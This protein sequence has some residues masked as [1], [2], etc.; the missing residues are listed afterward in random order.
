MI[1]VDDWAA[2]RRSPSLL[3][4]V[5]GIALAVGLALAA[6]A[7]AQTAGA[8]R[9]AAGVAS[10]QG[11]VAAP[12]LLPVAPSAAAMSSASARAI[13][14]QARV[15]QSLNLA[16]QANAAARAAAAGGGSAVPNGLTPGG[17]VVAPAGLQGG[18]GQ[19][20]GAKA[21]VQT[22]AAGA[23]LVTV[24]QTQP[25][26]LLSWSSFNIGRETT[27]A[28]TQQPDWIV[29][30]RIVDNIDP[31]TGAL[32][33]SMLRPSQILGKITAAGTVLVINQNGILF[34]P[35]AQVNTHS[36]LVASLEIGSRRLVDG[37]GNTTPTTLAQRSTSFLQNG[38]LASTDLLSA[39][40]VPQGSATADNANVEGAVEIAAGAQI[41]SAKGGYVI[42]AAPRVANAGE[43]TSVEGQ[44]SLQSGRQVTAVASSGAANSAD[45]DVRGLVLT[46]RSDDVKA[47]DGVA[48]AATGT[49]SAP[50]G[51]VSLG[52]TATAQIRTD[53]VLTATT[54][55]ARNGKIVLT[56]AEVEVGAAA[57]IAITPDDNARTDPESGSTVY[58]TIPQ[59]P[60]SVAAFKRSVITIGGAEN[61]DGVSPA[62]IDIGANALIYAPSATVAIGGDDSARGEDVA[63]GDTVRASAL[64]VA[65]GATIDVGGI[66]DFAVPADRNSIKI[67]PVKRNELRDTPNY[68]ETTTDGS[69]TLNGATLYVDPRKSGVRA[70]GVAWVG[71]PLVEAESYYHQVGV[72]VGELMTS[73]GSLTLGVRSY[74]L[75]SKETPA[76]VV[77]DPGAVLDISGG[78][79]S[80][81]AGFVRTSRLLTTDGRIVDI[82]IA[83]P[84]DNFVA[85]ID[86]IV[87]LQERAN[88]SQSFAN[89]AQ[90]SGWEPAYTEGRDAGALTIKG[91]TNELGGTLF[92]QAFA[93]TQQIANGRQGSAVP[94]IE[95]DLRRLQLAPSE[96]PA[97][98]LL[99][100]AALSRLGTGSNAAAIAGGADIVVRGGTAAAASPADPTILLS[101]D[102]LA[103]GGFAQLS[104]QTSG[105]VTLAAD[106]RIA[107]EPGGALVVDAGRAIRLD[108]TVEIPSGRIVARTYEIA[109][110]S[111]FDGADDLPAFLAADPNDPGRADRAAANFGLFDLTV[112][113]TLS[114]RGR[115]VND[116]L[117]ADGAYLGGA[118]TDGGSISLAVAPR[119]ILPIATTRNPQF[120]A[121][122]S[123]RLTLAGSAVLDVRG[124]AHV[125]PDAALALTGAGG[126]VELVNETTYFQVAG[127]NINTAPNQY[128]IGTD[129]SG[130]QTS[131]RFG[132]INGAAPD[133]RDLRAAVDIA[134]GARIEG[135]GFAAGGHFTLVTPDLDFGATSDGGGTRLTSD[136]IREAGFANYAITT[137]KSRVTGNVFA[138][139]LA[140]MT[141]LLDTQVVR[142]G[143]GEALDL[144]RSILND[145]LDD[146]AVAAVRALPTGGDV[147]SLVGAA[148]PAD[149]WDRRP[150]SLTFG[151]L[152]EV[153]VAA[154]GAVTGADGASLTVP[155]LLNSG[156]IRLPGGT[157]AQ[158]EALPAAYLAPDRAALGV[159][160]LSALFGAP[161]VAGRFDENAANLLGI[162]AGSSANSPV[163]SNAD[164]ATDSEFS[165]PIYFTA[166][167]AAS[168][169]VR[170]GAGSVTDL[171][172]TS[173]RN[174]RAVP[175]PGASARITGRL[176]DGGS[177]ATA[178]ART[179]A[180]ELFAAPD[181]GTARYIEPAGSAPVGTRQAALGLTAEGADLGRPAALL[182]IGGAA[183]RWHDEIALGSYALAPVWSDAG[184]L[185]LAGGGS[186]AGARIDAHGGA[187]AAR[188][189]TL[190]WANPILV[191]SDAP[192]M[193]AGLVS[194]DSITAAGFDAFVAQGRLSAQGDVTL[195][196]GRSFRLTGPSWTGDPAELARLT[197]TLAS[198]GAL[199][200]RA[201]YIRLESLQQAVLPRSDAGLGA[202]LITFVGGAADIVGAVYVEQ[203]VAATRFDLSG[204]LRLTGVQPAALA[205]GTAALA[206]AS[207]LGGEFVVNG[208]LTIKAAQVYPTTG[209]GSLQAA[210]D[211]ERGGAASTAV[212]YRLLSTGA[213]ATIRF[214][215]AQATDPAAPYSAGGNLLVQAAH[216]EQAG[217]LRV[218]LGRLQ[219]GGNAPLTL[220]TSLINQDV[221]ATATLDILA[222]STTSVSLGG[223]AG[224]PYG[225]TTD[226]LEYFF[227]P[228]S[229]TRLDAPPAADLR[230]AGDA[231]VIGANAN[232]DTSGGGDIYAYEFVPGVGG[233]RDVLDR[234]N[235]DAFSSNNGLQYADGRQ[236]YAVLP[237][238]AGDPVAFYDPIYSAD[239]ALYG[240]DA[241]KRVFLEAAPGLEEGWY[242]L[243][244]ARY[245]L[246]PGALRVVENVG[247][248]APARGVTATLR[249]GSIVVGGH[250]GTAGTAIEQSMRR[251]FTV[252]N[253]ATVRKFS[254]I[255]LTSATETFTDLA[256]RSKAALP[257]LPADAARLVLTPLSELR[258]ASP[259]AGAPAPGGRG[260]Q[261]DI[262]GTAFEILSPGAAPGGAGISLTTADFANLSAASLLIGGVRTDHADGT[263]SLDITTSTIRIANDA[264]SPLTAPEIV[265]AVD[266]R[267]NPDPLLPPV[268]P[269]IDIADGAVIAATGVL[270]DTRAGDYIIT[271]DGLQTA[272]GGIV[273]VANGPERLVSRPGATALA[274]SL[275]PA[276]IAI[277]DATLTGTAILLD[278]SRDL[279]ITDSPASPGGPRITAT[280]LALGGDDVFF[281]DA[282][283]G[284]L[285]LTV[286]PALEAQ[287][288]A[289]Q[290]LTIVTKSIVG[291]S[292]GAHRFNDLV[293]DAR[294]IR[295]FGQAVEPVK[296][297]S[298]DV[299]QTDTLVADPTLPIGV[300]IAARD[301]TL[302]NSDRDRGACSGIGVDGCGAT[303]NTLTIDAAAIHFASGPVRTYG[304]DKAVTFNAATG[305][306]AEGEASFDVGGAAITLGTPYLGDR[307]LVADP[308]GT[309]AQPALALATSGDVVIAKSAGTTASAPAAAP[310]ARLTIGDSGAP[311]RS[312]RID[313]A[314]LR[315][316]AGVIDIRAANDI[317]VAGSASIA[318]P[319]YAKTFGDAADPVT[320]SAPGG[321]VT[322]VSL[323]G[324]VDFA[325]EASV[326]VG[327]GSGSAGMLQLSAA[328]GAVRLPGTID[329]AAPSGKASLRLD[330]G[331]NPLLAGGSRQFDLAAFLAGPGAA[332]TG[333]VR[334]RTG[335]GDLVLGAGQTLRAES[336]RL[337]A[338]GGLLAIAGRID[339]SGI[340]GGDIGLFGAQ[341]VA[342][343][344]TASLDAHAAGYVATD[345]RSAT[346]GDIVI[347]TAGAGRIDVAAGAVIDVAAR[348]P[349]ARL[350]TVTRKDALTLSDT[351]GYDYAAPDEG[352]TL[353]LRAPVA[354]ATVPIGFAGTVGGAREIAVEGVRVFDLGLLAGGATCAQAADICINVAGQAV[355]DLAATPGA[356]RLA[357]RLPGSV[358]EFVQD[359]AIDTT[360]LGTLANDPTL[361]LRPGVELA[362][363]GDIVLASNWNL[364][365]GTVDT[366]QA[367]AAKLM[368]ASPIDPKLLYVVPGAEASVLENFTTFLYRTGGS[369]AGTAGVLTL[370][371]GGDLDIRGSITDGF[372]AF[373]DQTEPT[374]LSYQLGGGDRSYRPALLTQCGS[375]GNTGGYCGNIY[376]AYYYYPGA[377][378]VPVANGEIITINAAQLSLGQDL[379]LLEGA[380]DVV[381]PYNPLANTPGARGAATDGSGDPIGTAEL[382]PLLADGSAV[383][384]FSY[385]LVGGAGL[386]SADPLAVSPAS[387]GSVSVSGEVTYRAVPVKPTGSWAGGV[388]LFGPPN[389][390]ILEPVFADPRDFAALSEMVTDFDPYTRLNFG[391]NA[392]LRAYLLQTSKA[393]FAA[394]AIAATDYQYFGPANSPNVL[395][396]GFA[397]MSDYLQ[398]IAADFGNRIAN[399]E[400]GYAQPNARA[401]TSLSNP[402]LTARSLVRTGTGD[403]AIT[404]AGDV[405]LTNGA[406]VFRNNAGRTVSAGAASGAQVGGT[407]VYTAGRRV[408]PGIMAA[409][410]ADGS[411]LTVDAAAN[412][413]TASVGD[414][415]QPNSQ[416]ILLADPVYAD[417][418][419]SVSV[420]AGRDVLG[421]RDAWS[422]AFRVVRGATHVGSPTQLWR[423]G[424]IGGGDAALIV[425]QR[426]NIR[427]N[428]QLFGSGFGTLGGGDIEV[429]AWRD[430]REILAAADTSVTS[431]AV[432][433]GLTLV[434]W[435]GGDVRITAGRDLLGGQVDVAEGTATVRAGRNM[436]SSGQLRL[437]STPTSNAAP[438]ANQ[439][440][441]RV[442]NAPADLA[443]LGS[444]DIAG[445]TALGTR[446]T[447]RAAAA[448]YTPAAG[449]ALAANGDITLYNRGREL[450]TDFSRTLGPVPVDQGALLPGS[451]AAAS[452]FGDVDLSGILVDGSDVPLALVPSPTG[453]LALFAGGDIGAMTL[454]MDDGDPSLAPGALSAYGE[455]VAGTRLYGFPTV[456]PAVSD[457]QRRIAHNART[458]HAGDTVPVRIMAEGDID[459]VALAL[460][461]AARISAGGDI[462]D[463]VFIGQNIAADDVTRITAGGDIKASARVLPVAAASGGTV[464]LP[465]LQG[466]TFTLGGPGALFI[467]A[468]RDLGPFLN[469]ATL[470]G[471]LDYAGGILTVG[472]DNNPWLGAA[473]A[474]IYTMFGVAGGADFTAFRDYYVNPANAGAL[475]G[476]LFVQVPDGKGNLLPDRSQPI[477]SAKLIDWTLD[478]AY[479]ALVATYGAAHVGPPGGPSAVTAA[480]AFAVFA[481]LPSL[482]QQQFLID[483][484][485]FN[486]LAA[487]ADVSGPSFQQFKRGYAA[488]DRLFPA[489]RGYTANDLS[490]ASN[491]GVQVTT[492]NFDLRLASLET[493]RGG[494]I[495][496]L[497]P[498][499]RLVAGSVVATAAQ[500]ARR[501][502]PTAAA[503]NLFEGRRQPLADRTA[504]ARILAIPAG[505]EGILTLRGGTVRGFTDDDLLLNQSRLF[506]IDGG[507]VFLWSSNGDLN[508]GQGART[509]ANNPPVVVRF[510]PNAFGILDQAGTVAGA[511]IAA[512]PPSDSTVPSTVYLIAPAGTVDAGDA[513]VRADRAVVL[514]QQVANADSIVA[515]D[516]V[517]AI[518]GV[519]NDLAAISSASAASTA[520]AQAAEAVDPTGS[521]TDTGATRISVEV[522]GFAGEPAN[523]PCNLTGAARPKNCPVPGG[524]N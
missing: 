445:I 180:G 419:G 266:R 316:S 351:P 398:S 79:V 347:G 474:K 177:L 5:S 206:L 288:A 357:D 6:P 416:G 111:V 319:G 281:T 441:L 58:D 30:N 285:G 172:G 170:L 521:R 367:V 312:V 85:V 507:D 182:A 456:T 278:S 423:P 376:S 483:Q 55:V 37:N 488:V 119:V 396:A 65:A 369:A 395:T 313:G 64:H 337:T 66:K 325:P 39:I 2:S 458:T 289:A 215:R 13:A 169:G 11:A 254:R 155:K 314:A 399:G 50:R 152:T 284:F 411:V 147:A 519:S 492:G 3:R 72:R 251:S 331:L 81:A 468:G 90:G 73:G 91:S 495:A 491:G 82:S 493:V 63:S 260:A 324:N 300:T 433:G 22:D 253:E 31:A 524:G 105:K 234:A 218:P 78:W 272:I 263:T 414:D 204:D 387:A 68:R 436:A 461:K 129:R 267:A 506:T 243:L 134:A 41:G 317:A 99:K 342:L 326:S 425:D 133:P 184:S 301:L 269:R 380:P 339:T 17:L 382:F 144:N 124:G 54:S 48:N 255:E 374:Y 291:F 61:D 360:K 195:A 292:G 4:S 176:I 424:T 297:G 19:W 368:A 332:F 194:A 453:Q 26:A 222:G 186:L 512:Q 500:A 212:P 350:V 143:T 242:T 295:P 302:A 35:T 403:I 163:L 146:A 509:S 390:Q 370:R 88:F 345:T 404:A 511:G 460:P 181:F 451:L 228:A 192:G 294:G 464:D 198:T 235:A 336:V 322:L 346:G 103:S 393:Y 93:G 308:R 270:S 467:E 190:V 329:A 471:N 276:D 153:Q 516:K 405:D 20:T 38:L 522:L 233:S 361:V 25:R 94:A 173:I 462:S 207:S 28:F 104:L 394:N 340:N 265:L 279:T 46:S 309:K 213:D 473:G 102:Y 107:L 157:I 232:V 487:T 154:G 274:N 208:D 118:W 323:A 123:G 34:G 450:L 498:G 185:T 283:S 366:A 432:A 489:A 481:T 440:R 258:I 457:A 455:A 53:G 256:A 42:I 277:G 203:S 428:P 349:G 240:S 150:V 469:S 148:V 10:P 158:G 237:S 385:R 86:P 437:G 496:I 27:L 262:S 315:A 435:G 74:V 379:A 286:T 293:L 517:G 40:A 224:V 230:L 164:L 463:M 431:A 273:R 241:G 130:F 448:F 135:Q 125:R 199:T 304:F 307:A 447:A 446:E 510:D 503:F 9:A 89:A 59:G 239:Y 282:P 477:Y 76:S 159:A 166:A 115:F 187:A 518:A 341:G 127:A 8:L 223:L 171:S 417:G 377:T 465:V 209:T 421:R 122:L 60:E 108:G 287:F 388:E 225:T 257:R 126:D 142:I 36:F 418:G 62:V 24:E 485:Y 499:G 136:F 112:S 244:P 389:S 106:S 202:G 482:V 261:V 96:L 248:A 333:D 132:R 227:T 137:W 49:I 128:G 45:P 459:Q 69:F 80:Y 472:N 470:A 402:N 165:R 193:A 101:S 109:A 21:P 140:G 515:T 299:I 356:N 196:L 501:G 217:V 298:R 249:D 110:G 412:A 415:F 413:V 231:V 305:I 210:I 358:V 156:V 1:R 409:V 476:D 83:D 67:T 175:L 52:G 375:F 71:S 401:A 120:A 84:N 238:R 344:A 18:L 338:D 138:N 191:Q 430:V 514:A 200:V 189:G 355:L 454:T 56:G 70:D 434:S 362:Y 197:T 363:S 131:A 168:E 47:V 443:A 178:A 420:S 383:D 502:Y 161:D 33:S 497:G 219:L 214:E 523:D 359:F 311:V 386:S 92:A 57:L 179:G 98:G 354:G 247:E 439:L 449:V 23:M 310:G 264:T 121:D 7:L 149:A 139:P 327:G 75:G 145:Q 384:S 475:D 466:N 174:P 328:R 372:F 236:V 114:T 87:E 97:A 296:P 259:F 32:A 520:A 16:A 378:T 410:A 252:M 484:V 12:S 478:H 160:D 201:P 43:L 113:G 250:Y 343:A 29:L 490:G 116:A 444:I 167:L 504:A 330:T 275:Q 141:A 452:L 117:T 365:A 216:I 77:V 271:T 392:K 480:E 334:I 348:R 245:A 429:E 183:D 211:A 51:Y 373:G 246:L 397:L 364:G 268:A 306:Y 188:G 353:L 438:E 427:V 321:M 151:G 100:I 442:S 486:E 318:A 335:E 162:R 505:L 320:V 408:A 303:G 95:G 381:A 406:P 513:G 391:T 422:E 280:N 226:L 221:P 400:F 220:G 290:R 426:V 15:N 371:A 205:L 407:A 494:D 479:A 44:V 229:G 14:Q 508:A 352:G